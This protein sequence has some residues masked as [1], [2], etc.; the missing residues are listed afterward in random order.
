M[1]ILKLNKKL[2]DNHHKT[3][4]KN[5]LEIILENNLINE[6]TCGKIFKISDKVVIKLIKCRNLSL[7][8]YECKINNELLESLDLAI[9]L[10]KH[11]EFKNLRFSN[12]TT[13]LDFTG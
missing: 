9:I 3:L 11:Q 10:V 2:L 4:I 5:N 6:G 8:R 13:V 12:T 7:S 1:N